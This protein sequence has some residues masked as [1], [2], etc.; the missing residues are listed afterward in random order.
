MKAEIA[1]QRFGKLEA[2]RP[3]KKDKRGNVMWLCKCD[4]G[5]TKLVAAT[6][7]RTGRTK[8]CGCAIREIKD[9]TGTRSGKL[10]AL[11]PTDEKRH[12][13]TVW[14]CRCD[15]GGTRTATVNDILFGYV[16]SCGCAVNK[17]GMGHT[18]LYRVWVSMRQRCNN[19]NN[20]AYKWYGGK[21][22]KVCDEWNGSHNYE[23][24]YKWAM[25]SGYKQGLTIDRIDPDG[26]YEP[27]NCRWITI[28]EQQKNRS[29]SLE[30]RKTCTQEH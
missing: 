10:V 18:K 19:K 17:H 27:S 23:A 3:V 29:N 6:R 16:T 21:G 20:R 13:K 22:V 24:F 8:S 26:N 28:S 30:R 9:I 25:A 4:C 2:I 1:G 14:M 12:G 15:C 11:Y 5:N 7:L